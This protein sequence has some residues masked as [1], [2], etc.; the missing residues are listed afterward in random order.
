MKA[1]ETNTRFT[2]TGIRP[3]LRGC[4]MWLAEEEK[5][6]EE[7]EDEEEVAAEE[8]VEEE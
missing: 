4:H 3:V 5:E 7:E 1:G 2:S 8:G 6:K